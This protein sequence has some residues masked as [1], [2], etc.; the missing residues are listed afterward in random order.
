[1]ER[2][3]C[4]DCGALVKPSS[5]DRHIITAKHRKVVDGNNAMIFVDDPI[6]PFKCEQKPHLVSF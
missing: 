1:M 4:V 2:V 3:K 6:L 5:M